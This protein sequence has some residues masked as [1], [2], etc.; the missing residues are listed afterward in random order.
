MDIPNRF[1][2][3]RLAAA[4]LINLALLSPAANSQ[5]IP[6]TEQQRLEFSL[7]AKAKMFVE[8]VTMAANVLP[9]ITHSDITA[10]LTDTLYK[11]LAQQNRLQTEKKIARLKLNTTILAYHDQTLTVHAELRYGKNVLAVSRVEQAI[12]TESQWLTSIES[13]VDQLLAE[14]L[15]P[16]SSEIQTDEQE[17]YPAND[18]SSGTITSNEYR[19]VY[20]RYPTVQ[21][22]PGFQSDGR[23][24]RRYPAPPPP[25]PAPHHQ[26]RH[27]FGREGERHEHH[28]QEAFNHRESHDHPHHR[29]HIGHDERHSY[30]HDQASS[31]NTSPSQADTSGSVPVNNPAEPHRHNDH[32]HRN[33][34]VTGLPTEQQKQLPPVAN[35]ASS[36]AAQSSATM[37]S[38]PSSSDSSSVASGSS[39]SAPSSSISSSA[40]PASAETGSEAP[41][42]NVAEPHRYRDRAYR[43]S[44]VTGLPSEQSRQ[45]P[46]VANTA[47]V[48]ATAKPDAVN[49]TD[50]T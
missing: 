43:N 34:Q 42:N 33:S 18:C 12:D 25:A 47:S 1:A 49:S 29:D 11:K 6:S 19:P 17:C 8:P 37:P 41:L 30:V 23:Y 32:A 15:D 20:N 28:P 7:I 22:R 26:E 50:V 31:A 13:I 5:T 46:S 2:T 10:V 24:G 36:N 45:V 35:T 21:F 16:R 48:P 14:L 40:N 39:M 3:T 38:L 27:D 44:Q 9:P 4:L